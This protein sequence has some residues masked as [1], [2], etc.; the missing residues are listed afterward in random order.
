[1]GLQGSAGSGLSPI[2]PQPGELR[3]YTRFPSDPSAQLYFNIWANIS[4][5]YVGRAAGFDA[6]TWRRVQRI[7]VQNERGGNFIGR[8]IGIDLYQDYKPDQLTP[9]AIDHEIQTHLGALRPYSE[10]QQFPSSAP[11]SP[12]VGT[13]GFPNLPSWVPLP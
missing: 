1:M 4:Y 11:P 9:A 6:A 10:Y 7:L 8:Q 13:A 5:G 3:G 12:W 2:T